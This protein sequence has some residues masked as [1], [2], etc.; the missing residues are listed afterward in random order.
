LKKKIFALGA[1]LFLSSAA[2]ADTDLIHRVNPGMSQ[3]E[4]LR[5]V[6]QPQAVVQNFADAQGQIV[7]VWRYSV[8]EVAVLP[9]RP[10]EALPKQAPTRIESDLDAWQ[11]IQSSGVNNPADPL[12]RPQFKKSVSEPTSRPYS[13]TFLRSYYVV[14]VNHV[15]SRVDY[16]EGIL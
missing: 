2:F 11:R 15:V 7:Q 12:Y 3:E 10:K 9:V 16:S 14:F 8:S 1:C 5:L 13:N 6:G 4:V